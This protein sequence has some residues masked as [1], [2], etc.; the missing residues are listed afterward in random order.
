MS[1][2]K[3]SL[4]I[5]GFEEVEVCESEQ[6]IEN[7]DESNEKLVISSVS[8]VNVDPISA[9]D[10]VIEETGVCDDLTSDEDE[11]VNEFIEK[12]NVAKS[13]LGLNS[14]TNKAELKEEAVIEATDL[15]NKFKNYITSNKFDKQCKASAKKHGV[16]K[17][18]VK[19]RA[20]SGFLGT[21]ADV[22]GLTFT[23]VGDI[24][25]SGVNFIAYII[26]NIINF[27]VENLLRLVSALTLNCGKSINL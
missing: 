18:I 12:T 16:S 19:N 25:I 6:I 24:A 14:P 22:L 1:E 8:D 15:L 5:S 9:I 2:T 10:K 20:I 4:E 7:D 17:S 13:S 27:A 3:E 26:N 11:F 21:I 23:V